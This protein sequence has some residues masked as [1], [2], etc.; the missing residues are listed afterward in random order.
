MFNVLID[1]IRKQYVRI[2]LARALSARK[3]GCSARG[4]KSYQKASFL[5]PGDREILLAL[6]ET[7]LEAGQ[8]DHAIRNFQEYL[9]DCPDNYLALYGLACALINIGQVEA[10]VGYLSRG[11][12]IYPE[13][14]HC[15]AKAVE[16]ASS[17]INHPFLDNLLETLLES[18]SGAII[19]Y[20]AGILCF[21]MDRYQDAIAHFDATEK[22][23]YKKEA[24]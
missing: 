1:N 21:S 17:P 20:Y 2:L 15:L 9:E 24:L 23:G 4:V 10:A 13:D 11:I 7:C 16:L 18:N 3:K 12:A 14:E 8:V 5:M 22:M 6:A 19:R